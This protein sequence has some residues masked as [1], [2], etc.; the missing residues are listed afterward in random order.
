MQ[1]IITLEGVV[2]WATATLPGVPKMGIEIP[3]RADELKPLY[4]AKAIHY[5][6]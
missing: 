6:N 1:E 4:E 5:K 2:A 3:S